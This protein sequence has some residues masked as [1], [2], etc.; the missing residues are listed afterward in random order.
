MM[1]QLAAGY[2]CK[3]RF[4][5][6]KVYC[7]AMTNGVSSRDNHENK[8]IKFRENQKKTLK[9]TRIQMVTIE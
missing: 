1:K 5:G 3:A 4:R 6:D 2:N 9:D 8:D 7:V